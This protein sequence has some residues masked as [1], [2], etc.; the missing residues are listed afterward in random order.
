MP[1]EYLNHDDWYSTWK[2]EEE[3]ERFFNKICPRTRSFDNAGDCTN[4]YSVLGVNS[5]ASKKQINSAFNTVAKICHP[6]KIRG[7]Q[8]DKG[9]AV[10]YFSTA[11]EAKS[12]LLDDVWR[13]TVNN[14]IGKDKLQKYDREFDADAAR[15]N[16]ERSCRR[17]IIPTLLPASRPLH[18]TIADHIL[19]DR[20]APSMA[21]LPVQVHST[22]TG[23][24]KHVEWEFFKTEEP[25]HGYQ[26]TSFRPEPTIAAQPK[27]A[28]TSL[29]GM[30]TNGFLGA[31]ALVVT[32]FFLRGRYREH[33]KHQRSTAHARVKPAAGSGV[34]RNRE[35]AVAVS[36]QLV[37]RTRTERRER[38]GKVPKRGKRGHGWTRKQR[39]GTSGKVQ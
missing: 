5:T 32:I 20:I 30:Q 16:I 12:I 9:A 11:I 18:E 28:N 10:E 33:R 22:S 23:N 3:R 13:W 19:R 7:N 38:P 14:R 35:S 34:L 29:S 27:S 21:H 36:P 24:D 25:V 26:S 4:I 2:E 39:F 17:M 15:Q 1:S 8:V 6:D 37:K 31:A